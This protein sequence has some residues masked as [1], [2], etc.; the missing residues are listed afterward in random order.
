M[1]LTAVLQQTK[2][3]PKIWDYKNEEAE[4]NGYLSMYL[5]MEKVFIQ[6]YSAIPRYC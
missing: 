4:L 2:D 6:L 5:S 3:H 1:A